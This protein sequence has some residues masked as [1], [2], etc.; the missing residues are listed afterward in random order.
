MNTDL[1]LFVRKALEKG[2]SRKDIAKALTSSGWQAD[3]VKDALEAYAEYPF[4]VPVP[5][6]KPYLNAH[7]AFLYLIMFFTLYISAFSFG[8]I[9]FQF[10]ARWFPDALDLASGN[11]GV[12]LQ[13]IRS[14]L[15][16]IIIAFPIFL[17]ISSILNNAIRKNPE[18]RGSKIRKWL[19]YITLFIAATVII[20]D[21]IGLVLNYLGGA[22]TTP[23][24]LDIITIAAVA[25]AIFGYYLWD[26]RSDEKES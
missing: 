7:D 24:T 10:I 22:L 23:L 18:K 2:A 5:H 17:W 8:A 26:L 12:N 25:G 3:E 11:N 13:A 19:T 1:S 21:L 9:I 20:G 4:V 6:R 15:A 14:S 16:A